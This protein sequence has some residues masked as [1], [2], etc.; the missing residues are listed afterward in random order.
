MIS[1]EVEKAL[2]GQ[3][4]QEF[5]AAYTYLAMAAWFDRLR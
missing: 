5:T 4:N 1:A 3:I 2:A